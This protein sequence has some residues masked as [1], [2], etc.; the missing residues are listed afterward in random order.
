MKTFKKLFSVSAIV[1]LLGTLVPMYA[2]GANYTTE[3]VQA[4]DYAYGH[5]ITTMDS[6]DNAD[7]F[8][9]LTRIAMAK[10]LGNYAIDVLGLEPDT[11]KDCTFPD[12][13]AALD[14]QYDNWVTK[15]CQL[16]L[17][18][19]G[20]TNFNPNGLVTR[21][22]FGTAFSRALNA[23]D[24]DKLAEMNKADPYYK[25]HL[26]FLKEEGIMNNISDPNMKEVRGYVMLM[27]MR[28]DD[29]YTP[30]EGCSAEE[31]LK[32][33]TADDYDA[34]VA[35]CSAENPAE[36][37]LPGYAKVS[38][39]A[40]ATQEVAMNAVNK[41]VGTVTLKAGEN[42]TTISSIVIGHS[43]LGDASAVSAQL[44]QNG[45]AVS[46]QKNISKSS[47]Q[48][49][50]KLSPAVVMKA[51][52]SMTFDVVA[53]LSGAS[54]E[55]HNFTVE[56]VNVANGKADGTPVALGTLK[57]TSYLAGHV[58]VT[59]MNGGSVKAGD[60]DKT[61]VT[62]NVTPSKKGTI[63]GITITKQ[64]GNEDLDALVNNVKAYYNDEVI[65]TVK[66]TD[67]KIVISDLKIERNAGQSANIELRWDCIFVWS[68]VETTLTVDLNDVLA[69]ESNTNENMWNAAYATPVTLTVDG[70][71]LKVTNKTTKEQTV[72][73][74]TSDVE[75]LNVEVTSKSEL[76]VVDYTVSFTQWGDKF[77][78]WN[79]VD[80]IIT[81]YIDGEDYE[82]DSK[83]WTTFTWTKKESFVVE[84][85][86]TVK[87][88]AVANFTEN[89][90]G[91][92]KLTLALAWAKTTEW[93]NTI[94]LSK[95]TA[96]HLTKVLGAWA[97]VKTATKSAPVSTSLFENKDQEVARFAIK[98][99]NDKITV[100]SL[101][102]TAT[103]A[104]WATLPE[105]KNLFDGNLRL[106]NVENDEEID[107]TFDLDTTDTD[108]K[109]VVKDMNLAVE[110]DAT[111]NLKVM[112]NVG[113]IEDV[114]DGTVKL[115][116]TAWKFK[117]STTSLTNLTLGTIT[118]NT[119]TFRATAP[120]I[121]LAKA[122]DNM[123]EVTIKNLN[124]T[125]ILYNNLK[126][127]VRT[128]VANSDFSGRVCL[129]SDVNVIS[130]EDTAVL[131]SWALAAVVDNEWTAAQELAEN[132]EVTYYIL[133]DGT[134]IE[135]DVLRAEVSSLSYGTTTATVAPERYSISKLL[136]E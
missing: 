38:G 99:A 80:G 20:I 44:F 113:S 49:T 110:K 94:T 21:A 134:N 91:S 66:V 55:T 1:A 108:G 83:D 77:T 39:K 45:V 85:G 115:A 69:V 29:S 79:F 128:D 59:S 78:T 118:T 100:K 60:T 13:T 23:K 106:V 19:V 22:E 34:C 116:V 57:T 87:I 32:C 17:M 71:D 67:E 63:N 48:V 76:E 64:N 70:A 18:G 90:E 109:I 126:Y 27:M 33:L 54:N 81:L 124:D 15:A 114:M 2:F 132:D 26:N 61:L 16:G 74:G 86:R 82:L 102:L 5:K 30:T 53:S 43:G 88:R 47:Q 133:V 104:S 58:T 84:P 51:N 117:T 103:V 40:E 8:G 105:I 119:Y 56:A 10:M 37:N 97:T 136:N 93:N 130:C 35:A 96:W 11:T 73:P 112:A 36:E 12:V 131:S 4:Y 101:D 127:R 98:A 14:T 52:S 65:G 123:F 129:V 89:A 28:S 111:I 95:S 72:V 68:G 107:A 46:S 75:L 62:V 42:D 121:T 6:I 122:S 135:P 50:L 92:Y 7:M 25:D 24:A 120:E 31:L 9:N 125:G 41:K 3:L